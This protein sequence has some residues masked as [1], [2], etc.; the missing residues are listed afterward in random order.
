[1]VKGK[2]SREPDAEEIKRRY[3][4]LA[5]SIPDKHHR[6]FQPFFQEYVR[7]KLTNLK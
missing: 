1:V 5:G 7:Q 3:Q 2:R 6:V 4:Q